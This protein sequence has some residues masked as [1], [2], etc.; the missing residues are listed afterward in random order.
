MIGHAPKEWVRFYMEQRFRNIKITPE[1]IGTA[2]KNKVLR[3]PPNQR[4]YS[5]KAK[6]VKELLS[7]LGKVIAEKG[8]EYFLGTI[9]VSNQDEGPRPRVVDGQQ[10]LATT[11]IFIAGVRD[12]LSSQKDPEAGKLEQLYMFSPVMG[13]EDVD[14]ISMND[15]DRE[16]FHNRILV[17]PSH[18]K[19]LTDSHESTR[20]SHG[21]INEAART[22]KQYIL[23]LVK[24]LAPDK[25]KAL[26][27]DWIAFIDKNAVVIWVEVPDDRAAYTIFETMNDRG[28]DLSA[29]DLIKNHL[30][31]MADDLVGDAER[32]WAELLGAL[33]S[34]QQ[35]D[36]VKEFVRQYWISRNGSTRTQ[37]LFDEIK[38]KAS[39][40]SNAMELLSKLHA[41][42]ELY[43][44]LL[45][46][47]H[48]KWIN[49]NDR[50]RRN[51]MALISFGVKQIRPVLLAALERFT[52][53]EMEIVL[54]LAVSWSV[55][56][57]AAG[58][59][60]TGMVESAYGKSAQRITDGEIKDSREL[61]LDLTP[62]IPADDAFE[63]A[64]ATMQVAKGSL[65][66]YYLRALEQQAQGVDQPENIVNDDPFVI[67]LE[68]V[69]P[70]KPKAGEWTAF[71]ADQRAL[72]TGRL[73]N[74]AIL[75][76]EA[77]ESIDT[78]EFEKKKKVYVNS[79][80]VLTKELA[81]EQDWTP[82]AVATRQ[83]R[84]AVLAKTVWPITL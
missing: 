60:G 31:N 46:P 12:Y 77:N 72:F 57:L 49:Y 13:E 65:A 11:L 7:D 39:S 76:R 43:V 61:A 36:V 42:A 63:N 33:E 4:E 55:R 23:D 69:L 59:Q 67:N 54:R 5:W 64:F 53:K 15:R 9:V 48:A 84:L 45:N 16:Y 14:R 41:S 73:G 8:A 74:L 19:R 24:N 29:V 18:A 40:K 10:R 26:L 35:A 44:A 66:R 81:H 50:T 56:L 83:K 25:A 32:K 6:H 21:L 34:S 30:F 68:H 37:E 22:V 20:P 62:T 82:Q 28:L 70:E 58:E 79:S 47:M 27:L 80:F 1:H 17:S 51:L 52:Q 3:V 75:Q 2:L 78:S 38:E 71:D